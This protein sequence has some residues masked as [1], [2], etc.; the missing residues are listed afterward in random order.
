MPNRQS[1]LVT[2]QGMAKRRKEG[3]KKEKRRKKTVDSLEFTFLIKKNSR[4]LGEEGG[5]YV[6]YRIEGVG[7]FPTLSSQGYDGLVIRDLLVVVCIG[8]G[9]GG[10][11]HGSKAPFWVGLGSC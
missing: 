9:G 5:L 6:V 8:G 10:S 1:R 11:L 4:T 7:G 3:K 2:P